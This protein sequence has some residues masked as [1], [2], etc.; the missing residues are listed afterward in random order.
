MKLNNFIPVLIILILIPSYALTEEESHNPA[1]CNVVTSSSLSSILKCLPQKNISTKD[2]ETLT[3]NIKILD[4]AEGKGAE[5][6]PGKLL[7]CQIKTYDGD[8]NIL[9]NTVEERTPLRFIFGDGTLPAP[10][11]DAIATMKAGGRRL[12]YYPEEVPYELDERPNDYERRFFRHKKTVL[13]D[14]TLIW[15]RELELKKMRMFR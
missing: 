1:H 8:C 6:M 15:V 4:T 12:V 10:F 5:I 3:H 7:Y 13:Y 11:E 9:D 14:V 2:W